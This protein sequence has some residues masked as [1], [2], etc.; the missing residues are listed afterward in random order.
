MRILLTNDDGIH[1]AGLAALERI[2][3]KISDDVWVV[4]PET[5]QSG[6]SHSL[7]MNDPLRL[8]KAGEKRFAVNGTPSDCVIMATRRI[9]GGR[10]DLILSGVNSGTNVAD[11]VTYSGTIAAAIE[12]TL[13]G[14]RSVALSQ[15]Y[16]YEDDGQRSVP[17]AT[18]EA[19]APE[20]ISKLV[21]FGFPANVLYNVNFPNRSADAIAGI[22]VTATG[23]L[24]HGLHVDERRDGRG[25]PYFW[26][27]YKREKQDIDPGTDLAAVRDGMISV[28][29]LRLDLTAHDLGEPLRHHFD[30]H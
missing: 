16:S 19:H 26:L 12:G 4:A 22:A 25:N 13:L 5:D 3:A 30:R 27:T 14:V 15:G 17:W 11:D 2:A 23:K 20:I 8:R 6:L 18:A 28:T 7:T 29:P 21:D 9:L 1:A 24:A 10:P